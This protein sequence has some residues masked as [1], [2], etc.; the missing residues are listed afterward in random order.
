[1]RNCFFTGVLE[2]GD[3]PHNMTSTSTPFDIHVLRPPVQTNELEIFANVFRDLRLQSLRESPDSFTEKHDAVST[4]PGAYWKDFIQSHEGLIQI[5]FALPRSQAVRIATSENNTRAEYIL[6][7]GRPLS[8]AVNTGPIPHDRFLSPPGSQIPS[9]RPDEQEQRYHGGML[10]HIADMRGQRGER[11]I[12]QLI[13]DRD[14]W[15]LSKLRSNQ[16]EIPPLARCRG[17][18]KPGRN[19][20]ALLSFYV[21]SGW[22]IAGTQTWRTNLLAEGGMAA[23]RAAEIRGDNMDEIS[24]VVEKI[25]TVPHLEWQIRSNKHLLQRE[26]A[27]L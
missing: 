5:A 7:H 16:N 13:L 6:E 25:F 20:E 24:V 23:V 1:M 27:R 3:P 11:L 2:Q 17:N 12:Q 22:Y 9:D 19:Q 10:F 26:K 21:R 8:M 14:E 15:L 4:R 18:V